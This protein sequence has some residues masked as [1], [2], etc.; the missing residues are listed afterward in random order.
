MELFKTKTYFIVTDNRAA[1]ARLA[2]RFALTHRVRNT[3]I[4]VMKYEDSYMIRFES[5]IGRLGLSRQL[6][7]TF[8]NRY[9][10]RIGKCAVLVSKET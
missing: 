1:T 10:V 9:N 5:K 2:E 6:K 8:G 4:G 3:G 7:K